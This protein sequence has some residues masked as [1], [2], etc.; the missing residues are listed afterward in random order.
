MGLFPCK[1]STQSN[2][3][4][5]FICTIELLSEILKVSTSFDRNQNLSQ[6]FVQYQNCILYFHHKTFFSKHYISGP[7]CF[8]IIIVNNIVIC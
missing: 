8:V 2:L 4:L 3:A 7:L 5:P 6:H 1:I